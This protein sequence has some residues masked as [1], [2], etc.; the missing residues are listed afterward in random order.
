MRYDVARCNKEAEE[1]RVIEEKRAAEEKA[2]K[3]ATPT[4]ATA[5]AIA[6]KD[7]PGKAVQH[8]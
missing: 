8:S 3:S 7:S 4:T 6:T 1:K 2:K 5:K